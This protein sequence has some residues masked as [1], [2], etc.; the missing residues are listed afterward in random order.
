M[1]F[2]ESRQHQKNGLFRNRAGIDPRIVADVN[3][4][5]R[6]CR[7]VDAVEAHAEGVDDLQIRHRTDHLR[8][9]IDHGVAE[10]RL[11]AACD[12]FF[13]IVPVI[14]EMPDIPSFRHALAIRLKIILV[15]QK[16]CFHCSLLCSFS[17]DCPLSQAL[18][19]LFFLEPFPSSGFLYR[20]IF[21]RPFH[22]HSFYSLLIR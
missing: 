18:L 3:A 9:H 6:G 19:L 7:K 2:P 15:Y 22:D 21:F 10:N 20:F 17:S 16:C 12:Q 5:L 11:R 13:R 4:F 8:R 14:A 1:I